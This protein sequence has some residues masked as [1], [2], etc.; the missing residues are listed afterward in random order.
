MARHSGQYD[1]RDEERVHHCSLSD[2]TAILDGRLSARLTRYYWTAN[3]N[4]IEDMGQATHPCLKHSASH[5]FSGLTVACTVCTRTVMDSLPCRSFSGR[6]ALR[7]ASEVESWHFC[8]GEMSLCSRVLHYNL[9][10]VAARQSRLCS[11]GLCTVWL[12]EDTEI[13]KAPRECCLDICG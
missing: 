13:F 11:C 2:L 9:V 3:S 5:P 6:V 8:P 4:S 10:E 1:S 12:E 7:N